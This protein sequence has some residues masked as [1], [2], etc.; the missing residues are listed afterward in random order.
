MDF[1]DASVFTT[2]FSAT[3]AEKIRKYTSAQLVKDG[4]HPINDT[5][6]LY[7]FF[8]TM[9]IRSRFRVTTS[10][11]YSKMASSQEQ[12]HNIKLMPQ[13]RYTHILNSL[14]GYD[15]AGRSGSDTMTDV[16]M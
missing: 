12:Q 14:R 6:E 4:R 16:W 9:F 3:A 13:E 15:I 5:L 1:D 7:Q 8:A 10:L 11:F 2:L